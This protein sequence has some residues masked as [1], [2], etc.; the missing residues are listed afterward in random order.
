LLLALYA[1]YFMHIYYININYY[2]V[3]YFLFSKYNLAPVDSSF[4]VV[5]FSVAV[6]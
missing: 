1:G 4:L 2:K 6:T 3:V 5:I